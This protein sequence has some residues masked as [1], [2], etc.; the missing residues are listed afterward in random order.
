MTV[1][2]NMIVCAGIFLGAA[3]GTGA[4]PEPARAAPGVSNTFTI[5]QVGPREMGT[6]FVTATA[7]S[8]PMNCATSWAVRVLTSAQNYQAIVATMLTAFSHAIGPKAIPSRS[9]F[10][11]RAPI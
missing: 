4:F 1:I 11:S 9:L 5:T 8:S 7:V 3:I 10:A 2:R 6:D